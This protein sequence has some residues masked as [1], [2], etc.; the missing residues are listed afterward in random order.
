MIRNAFPLATLTLLSSFAA[1]ACAVTPKR[2][3]YGR[4]ESR[5]M[6]VDMHY[7]VYTPPGFS[8]EERLPLVLFLHGGGDSEKSFD[9]HAI[10][11]RLDDAIERG[12][13]PR[14]VVALPEGDLGFWTNWRD[15][16]RNYE[17]W[18]VR[19]LLPHVQREYH[20]ARCPEGCHVMG[21]SMGGAGTLRFMF[22]HPELFASAGVISAPVMDTDAMLSFADDRLI[23]I[24]VPTHRVWGTPTRAQVAR[25]DPFVAWRTAEDLGM[26]LFLAWGERDRG[27]IVTGSERLHRHLV[28]EGIE[29]GFE[30]F[31]GGHDW[32]SW[33]PVIEHAIAHGVGGAALGAADE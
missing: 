29:H 17:D 7:S 23:K 8:T 4:Y 2:L 15:G 12:S 5:A 18:V 13:V 28:D 21:V 11:A 26:R 33:G 6:R 24:F 1:S 9:Q 3:E 10:G 27:M 25:E 14:V 22:H 32:R 16:S 20:T 19:E 31:P 30:E